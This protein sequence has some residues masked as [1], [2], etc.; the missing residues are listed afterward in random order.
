[1]TLPVKRWYAQATDR[2]IGGVGLSRHKLEE[3]LDS[4]IQLF[5]EKGYHATSMQDLAD[6]VGLQKGS[7]Y[8]HIAS[9][10]DL[11]LKIIEQ[12]MNVLIAGVESIMSENISPREKLERAVANHIQVVTGNLGP[13]T[14]FIRETYALTP[15]QQAEIRAT[16]RRYRALFEQILQQGV[17]RGQ[18][19]P[20]DV[21]L[22][23]LAMFGLGNSIYQWYQ[24][25][26]RLRPAEIARQFVDLLLRG[27][28]AEGA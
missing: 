12:A 23:S 14:V 6:A 11:L 20:H 22:V 4:A 28:L 5:R 15:E 2:L 24:P 9:K 16:R 18:F 26:G 17:D 1:M 7:L 19:R 25:G 27:I 21:Q 13:L 8:H 3:I 10:E